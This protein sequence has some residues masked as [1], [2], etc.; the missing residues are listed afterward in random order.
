MTANIRIIAK[1]AKDGATFTVT[2]SISGMEKN[3]ADFASKKVSVL[4][5]VQNSRW[6]KMIAM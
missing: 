3:L 1:N 5:V 2:T 4:N 6:M